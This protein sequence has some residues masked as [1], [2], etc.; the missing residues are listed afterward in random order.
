MLVVH[1][2]RKPG[3]FVDGADRREGEGLFWYLF[4][5]L[6]REPTTAVE[7]A[8]QN[9]TSY[10]SSGGCSVDIGRKLELVPREGEERFQCVCTVVGWRDAARAT[11]TVGSD[12][13]MRILLRHSHRGHQLVAHY[14][15]YTA[16]IQIGRAHV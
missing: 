9:G 8:R 1:N 5:I 14:V 10:E 3:S 2:A 6:D 16:G 12:I 11:R 7:G 13:M 4:L 15:L